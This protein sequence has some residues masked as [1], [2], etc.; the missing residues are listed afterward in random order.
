MKINTEMDFPKSV[1]NLT[2]LTFVDL[3][4]IGPT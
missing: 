3:G 1:L 2:S 4:E